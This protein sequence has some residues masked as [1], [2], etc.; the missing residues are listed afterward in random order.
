[1]RF[2]KKCFCIFRRKGLHLQRFIPFLHTETAKTVYFFGIHGTSSHE[3]SEEKNEQKIGV[4]LKHDYTIL[5]K[6]IGKRLSTPG[7]T[8]LL[9]R[10]TRLI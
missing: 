7:T 1:M 5:Y 10:T 8:C 9:S 3:E 6:Y 4:S 2:Q